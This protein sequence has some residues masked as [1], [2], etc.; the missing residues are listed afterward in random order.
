LTRDARYQLPTGLHKNAVNQDLSA[1]S[2]VACAILPGELS[3]LRARAREQPS[4]GLS[5]RIHNLERGLEARNLREAELRQEWGE[6]LSD[7]LQ[8]GRFT[9]EAG[10]DFG[11]APERDD[12]GLLPERG[13]QGREVGLRTIDRYRSELDAQSGNRLTDLLDRDS[14]GLDGKYLAAVGSVASPNCCK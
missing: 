3:G 10:A 7:G 14:T 13:R 11:P 8:S 2:S 12:G 5:E 9:T 1:L 6:G 4:A